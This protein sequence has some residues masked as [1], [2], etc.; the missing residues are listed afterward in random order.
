VLV[1]HDDI[2][3]IPIQQCDKLGQPSQERMG[4]TAL[5]RASNYREVVFGDESNDTTAATMT[6]DEKD[7]GDL[8]G[9]S[10]DKETVDGGADDTSPNPTL[11]IP[12]GQW[13]VDLDETAIALSSTPRETHPEPTQG[14]SLPTSRPGSRSQY[15]KLADVGSNK[16]SKTLPS[17]SLCC[18]YTTMPCDA[19]SDDE[20]TNLL[21]PV[22]PAAS[23][24]IL[25]ILLSLSHYTLMIISV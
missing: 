16:V 18:Y 11:C 5:P 10:V 12:I 3:D 24:H 8:G 20:H 15:S 6:A 1:V 13:K 4:W 17:P 9:V 22:L 25:L 19:D 14:G 21:Y 2:K 7:D 23:I